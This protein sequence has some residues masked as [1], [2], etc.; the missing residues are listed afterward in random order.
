MPQLAKQVTIARRGSIGHMEQKP[1]EKLPIHFSS[2]STVDS[3]HI[4]IPA[5]GGGGGFGAAA[6]GAGAG[7]TV[8]GGAG[9][10]AV[11]TAP[12]SCFFF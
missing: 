5:G 1:A 3:K 12:P 9:A 11:E 6:A 10:A 7:V 4:Y 8:A 2:R